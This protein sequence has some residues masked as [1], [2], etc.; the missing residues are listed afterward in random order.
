MAGAILNTRH[1]SFGVLVVFGVMGWRYGLQ[2][3]AFIFFVFYFHVHGEQQQRPKTWKVQTGWFLVVNMD[4]VWWQSGFSG[5]V[6][7][8]ATVEVVG[9]WWEREKREEEKVGEKVKKRK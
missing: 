6:A 2:N 5:G 4:K 3:Q 9:E 7:T 1:S 8:S